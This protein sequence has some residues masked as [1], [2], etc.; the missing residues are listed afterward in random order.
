MEKERER[1][2]DVR[3][4]HWSVFFCTSSAGDLAHNPGMCSD[5][6]LNQQPLGSQ[7]STQST[8]TH[9]PEQNNLT[10]FIL[11]FINMSL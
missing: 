9:Q 1:N 5:W 7:A 4:M 2:I 6:E 3:E 10:I 11:I 8:E